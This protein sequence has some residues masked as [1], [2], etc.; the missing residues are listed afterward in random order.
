MAKCCPGIDELGC[1]AGNLMRCKLLLVKQKWMS[2]E[3]IYISFAN[4]FRGGRGGESGGE[5][6]EKREERKEREKREKEK[7][8]GR[9]GNFDARNRSLGNS[10]T[11]FCV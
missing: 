4:M 5:K 3:G 7:R 6:R 9:G 10:G 11:F 1:S 8:F 2:S